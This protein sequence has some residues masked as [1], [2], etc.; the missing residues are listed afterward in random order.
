MARRHQRDQSRGQVVVTVA[1]L[2]VLLFGILAVAI[3]LTVQTNDR[4]NLQNV[5]DFAALSGVGVLN[6]TPITSS[7]QN[8]AVSQALKVIGQNMGW[9]TSWWTGNLSNYSSSCAPN[10]CYTITYG[11]GP[12]TV[13]V[14]SPPQGNAEYNTTNYLQVILH[15]VETNSIAG[16]IGQPTS[17]VG[18]SAIAYF[19]GPAQPSG[20]ALYS[21]SLVATGNQGELVYGDTYVGEGIIPQSSGKA[22]FC[23]LSNPG[24]GITSGQ[25]FFAPQPPSITKFTGVGQIQTPPNVQYSATSASCSTTGIYA[26]DPGTSSSCS[27]QG[28][29][30]DST[31]YV[32][33]FNPPPTPPIVETPQVPA[34]YPGDLYT[35]FCGTI[36]SSSPQGVYDISPGCNLKVDFSNNINCISIVLPDSPS[37]PATLTMENSTGSTALTAYGNES[38][39]LGCHGAGYS[40][41]NSAIY[42]PYDPSVDLTGSSSLSPVQMV[43]NS[44]S[45]KNLY[46]IDGA[47]Y[48]PSGELDMTSNV[49]I[50][51][52][53]QAIV[54]V[55]NVQTGNHTNPVV[56]YNGSTSPDLVVQYRLVS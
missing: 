16:I 21:A 52:I 37:N 1:L 29:T 24:L 10:D 36:N 12:Y 14:N 34:A 15:Y 11:K 40:G 38:K 28:A 25:I 32:C 18:G 13:T 46:T 50:S 49:P 6:A 26:S 42:A 4:R 51:I 30:W 47:V 39:A 7:N 20:W 5:A 31:N 9:P 33:V 45:S 23:A 53:G 22:A 41:N 17:T 8:A 43:T 2:G 27:L 3:D 19:S 48:M 54:G 55:W 44:K 56:T 35:S